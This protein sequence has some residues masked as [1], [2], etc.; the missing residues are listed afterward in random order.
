M[1]KS[2]FRYKGLGQQVGAYLVLVAFL[3]TGIVPASYAQNLV[4]PA[5]GVMVALSASQEPSV[6]KGLKVYPQNPFRLDFILDPGDAKAAKGA[7]RQGDSADAARLIKYFLAAVTVPEQDLWVNLSPYEKDRI[8]PEAFGVTEMGRDLLAQDYILKQ[9]TA[10]LMYPEGDTGKKFWAKV[11]A[12][13]QEKYGTIDIPVDTFN[14]VWIVPEKSA[15]Y[16]KNDAAFVVESRLKVMLET[17][18]LATQHGVVG[19]GLVPALGQGRPQVSPLHGKLAK[20]VLREVIIPLLEKEVNEGENFAPLRQVF[21]S[22]ILATWYKGKIAGALEEYYVDQN[23]TGGVDIEDRAAKEKI[24]AQ[25]VEAFKKGVF[26]YIKDENAGAVHESP[27]ARKYF[28]GGITVLGLGKNLEKSHDAAMLNGLVSD[29][30]MVVQVGLDAVQGDVGVFNASQLSYQASFDQFKS[31]FQGDFSKRIANRLAILTTFEVLLRTLSTDLSWE[32][33]DGTVGAIKAMFTAHLV[34][35]DDVKEQKVFMTFVHKLVSMEL[36]AVTRRAY[37]DA[38]LALNNTGFVSKER[39][40]EAHA[41]EILFR[42]SENNRVDWF[43][44]QFSREVLADWMVRGFVQEDDLKELGADDVQLQGMRSKVSAVSAINGEVQGIPMTASL[45]QEDMPDERTLESLLRTLGSAAD[46]HDRKVAVERISALMAGGFLPRGDVPQ[47]EMEAVFER[48]YGKTLLPEGFW[49]PYLR[50][51]VLLKDDPEAAYQIAFWSKEDLQMLFRIMDP[52]IDAITVDALNGSADSFRIR[53]QQGL[54]NTFKDDIGKPGKVLSRLQGE[55]V[56][57]I[58]KSSLK[59]AVKVAGMSDVNAVKGLVKASGLD[60]NRVII[61]YDHE[62]DRQRAQELLPDFQDAQPFEGFKGQ[63][64]VRIEFHN[65]RN[66]VMNKSKGSYRAWLPYSPLKF[67]DLQPL[68]MEKVQAKKDLLKIGDRKV[69]VLGSTTDMEFNEF[70]KIFNSLYDNDPVD[71][72]PLVIVGFRQVQM[73]EAI[74]SKDYLF[75]PD[76]EIRSNVRVDLPEVTDKKVLVVNTVGEMLDMYALA[77]IVIMGSDR[78]IIEPLSQKKIVLTFLENLLTNEEEILALIKAGGIKAFSRENLIE[79]LGAASATTEMIA[80]GDAVVEGFRQDGVFQ[81]ME[82]LARI[83]GGHDELRYQFL[84]QIT[85]QQDARYMKF[86]DWLAGVSLGRLSNKLIILDVLETLV[87]GLDD[88]YPLSVRQANARTLIKFMEDGY[89]TRADVRGRILE[90]GYIKVMLLALTDGS[91][92]GLHASHGDVLATLIKG[93]LVGSEDFPEG[94][95]V[96]DLVSVLGVNLGAAEFRARASVLESLISTGMVLHQEVLARIN[97]RAVIEGLVRHLNPQMAWAVRKGSADALTA[98]IMAGLVERPVLEKN[99][100]MGV[101]LRGLRADTVSDAQGALLNALTALIAK[102]Y[103]RAGDVKEHKLIDLF[104]DG[105]VKGGGK[106]IRL[107][108]ARGLLALMSAGF[109]Y[110]ENVDVD[111]FVKIMVDGLGM[112][113]VIEE[114]RQVH[115]DLLRVSMERGLFERMRVV[116][117]IEDR[118]IVESVL[119]GLGHDLYWEALKEGLGLLQELVSAGFVDKGRV[120]RGINEKG[121]LNVF[122]YRIN[123]ATDFALIKGAVGALAALV[124]AD[125]VNSTDVQEQGVV[126]VFLKGLDTNLSAPLLKA[127]VD[128]LVALLQG[129]YVSQKRLALGVSAGDVLGFL[130]AALSTN[131]SWSVADSYKDVLISLINTGLVNEDEMKSKKVVESILGGLRAVS[132]ESVLMGQNAV[133]NVLL[134]DGFLVKEPGLTTDELGGMFRDIHDGDS[135]A[136]RFLYGYLNLFVLLKDDPFVAYQLFGLP[137]GELKLLWEMFDSFV[138]GMMLDDGRVGVEKYDV[139]LR[140]EFVRSFVQGDDPKM[141]FLHFHQKLAELINGSSVKLAI[142]I[143]EIATVNAVRGFI[144]ASGLNN[145]K[146][147]IL[148]DREINEIQAKEFFPGHVVRAYEGFRNPGV[149]KVDFQDHGST[150]VRSLYSLEPN[151]LPMM[152]FKFNLMTASAQDVS[153]VREELGISADRE[154]IVLGSPISTEFNEFM[155]VYDALYQDLPYDKRP[156]LIV[157]FRTV[158]DEGY[159]R[160]LDGFAHQAIE[161]RSDARASWP[162]VQG[163]NVVVLN[164]KGELQKVYALSTV[165]VVGSDRNIFEPIIQKVVSLYFEGRWGSNTDAKNFLLKMG[166]IKSFSKENLERLLGRPP[167]AAEMI[168]RGVETL[169]E[170]RSESVL[171]AREFMLQIIGANPQMRGLLLSR[172]F[173]DDAQ[174]LMPA[175]VSTPG[176]IDLTARRMDLKTTGSGNGVKFKMNATQVQQLRNALGLSPVII[177]VQPLGNL[178]RFFGN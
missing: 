146:V 20:D 173:T 43:T 25:Y 27:V 10:S 104:L 130:V 91:S 131:T 178:S 152:P 59:V 47:A 63:G 170:I 42:A 124:K 93:G 75:G 38:L 150:K 126:E 84:D 2:I 39:V 80:K 175:S 123:S 69:I 167:E 140:K 23:K 149:I 125:F 151:E 145:D 139:S 112:G 15:V 105:M 7:N 171:R 106:L 3:V 163:H 92:V 32:V 127:Y 117:E 41:V 70:M 121:I 177:H 172:A 154:I 66:S 134:A 55:I 83:I 12:A 9:I 17:D 142:R 166:A 137:Q 136:D 78:N 97:E 52:L 34:S 132:V 135:L 28:A 95:F 162:D 30:D 58:N 141:L 147:I 48:I 169:K 6:L 8:T 98:L 29:R 35:E 53:V 72:R 36:E 122:L 109:V 156:L 16:E 119:Q 160:G 45:G 44:R 87:G 61:L 129:G 54:I 1:K 143:Y 118:A 89:V 120:V 67:Y 50:M 99:G 51:M 33:L 165:A 71:Q 64:A 76:V 164:T 144:R 111:G 82:L 26:N 65:Y 148:Y 116:R 18:Y 79:G 24:W 74:R 77:D 68:S 114:V 96:G 101:V 81:S 31:W 138:A 14:K 5:P 133:L 46:A 128:G 113:S 159:L 158:Q 88:K 108:Y 19:A 110:P 94:D 100:L 60:K 155:Q 4:L 176:G 174:D 62:I 73:E 102:G 86:K 157:G 40:R 90:K 115:W 153:G 22:L 49:Y 161:I 56:N 57:L 11:Y 103:V 13:A 85:A 107:G 168:A 21:H 37:R